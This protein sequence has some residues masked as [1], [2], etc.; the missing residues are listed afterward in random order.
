MTPNEIYVIENET[1]RRL[2]HIHDE[3]L[4]SLKLASVEAYDS[5]SKDGTVVGNFLF[6]PAGKPKDQ[7]VTR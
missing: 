5:K 6:W 2:T 3:F 4:K 7:E 1:P